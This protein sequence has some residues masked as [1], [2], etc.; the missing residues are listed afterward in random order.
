MARPEPVGP[1]ASPAARRAVPRPRWPRY[2]APFSLGTDTGGSIRQ[3]AAVCG[4][5]GIKPTYGGS[6][7]T[8]WLLSR[9]RWTRPAR[10]RGPCRRRAAARG[11][12]RARPDGLHL[13]DAPSAGGRR[14]APRRR[15]RACGRRG[16][17]VQRRGLRA[18]RA[19]AGSP[20][21]VELLEELGAKIVEVSLPAL[22]VRA[23]RLLPDRAERVPRPTWPASTAMRYGL[24]IGDDGTGTPRRSWR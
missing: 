21:R 19:V 3:P 23:A 7:A 13:V 11:D 1:R 22:Q 16:R 14:G 12:R 20:R 10:S 9:P 2:E 5:V 4:I 18:R 24:R 15:E 6:P 17:R 8:A